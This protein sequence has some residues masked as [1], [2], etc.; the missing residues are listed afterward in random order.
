MESIKITYL[1]LLKSMLIKESRNL[2]GQEHFRQQH[3]AMNLEKWLLI[4]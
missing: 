3:Q 1:L 4:T 2:I